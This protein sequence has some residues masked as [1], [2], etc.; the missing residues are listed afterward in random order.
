MPI[1]ELVLLVLAMSLFAFFC[2]WGGQGHKWMRRFLAPS[3]LATCILGISFFSGTFSAL[4][5]VGALWPMPS[6][7]LLKYGV[8]DGKVWKKVLLRALYGASLGLCGLLIGLSTGQLMLGLAQVLVAGCACTYFGVVNPFSSLGDKGVFLE[9]L[10]IYT[11]VIVL[12]P[13]ILL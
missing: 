2:A 8:N 5:F 7:L 1:L 9:D 3:I 10:C 12:L 6:M 4:V 13:L 11:G